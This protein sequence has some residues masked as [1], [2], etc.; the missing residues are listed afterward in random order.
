MTSIHCSIA[1]PP[2]FRTEDILQF[3]RRDPQAF[4][5][6]VAPD[7]LQKGLVVDG[8]AACLS[9]SFHP[10]HVDAE[11]AI[12]GRSTAASEQALTLQVC[13]ML[14]LTQRIEVFERTIASIPNSARS[15]PASPAC[16]CRWRQRHSRR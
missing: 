8:K 16:A 15:S 14:G 10:A 5:E 12:D 9:L 6:R 3:H 1:L 4:A 2:G 11:L 13:R 7:R